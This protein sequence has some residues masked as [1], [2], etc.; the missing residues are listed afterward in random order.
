MQELHSQTSSYSKLRLVR[1]RNKT[2]YSSVSYTHLDVYKRQTIDRVEHLEDSG[3]GGIGGV[4][5]ASNR[6]RLHALQMGIDLF[7][8]EVGG[9]SARFH[10]RHRV[11]G[12]RDVI[13][14]IGGVGER[15][16][17]VVVEI[18]EMCIRDSALG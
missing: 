2:C 5:I 9:L 4:R 14:H 10:H 11:D 6:E 18:E 16:R 1:E 12:N 8:G 15:R 13:R 7:E 17:V 3:I